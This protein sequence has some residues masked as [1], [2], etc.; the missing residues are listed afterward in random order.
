MEI[1]RIGKRASL[2][3]DIARQLYE[4]ILSSF[5]KPG[6]YLPGQREL[7]ERFG[8]STATMR[9]ALSV[10]I[11]AGILSASPG[12][13]TVIQ[14]INSE[15]ERFHGWLGAPQDADEVFELIEARLVL[16]TFFV[17]KSTKSKDLDGLSSL[18]EHLQQM[19]RHI[20]NP[21]EY[22]KADANFHR[23]LAK[24]SQNRVLMRIIRA[25]ELPILHMCRPANERHI[26]EHGDLH[27]SLETH[28]RLVRALEEGESD[29]AVRCLEEMAKRTRNTFQTIQAKKETAK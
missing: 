25:L 15:D 2:S 20:A 21:E 3:E 8:A 28:R 22:L 24:S 10:L 29:E 4:N 19:E 1:K 14:G 7:A 17:L 9:E 5:L 11:A 18:K 23:A 6:D 13:G 26:E 12:R 16:E 27:I